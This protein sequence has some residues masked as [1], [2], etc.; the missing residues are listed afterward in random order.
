MTQSPP[1]PP[2]Q[3]LE[4]MKQVLVSMRP[5]DGDTR[6]RWD[7][8]RSGAGTSG[9]GEEPPR[10]STEDEWVNKG[11]ATVFVSIGGGHDPGGVALL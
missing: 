8:T 10:R 11:R 9:A 4:V 3:E 5:K 1:P 7:G 2:P 6:S